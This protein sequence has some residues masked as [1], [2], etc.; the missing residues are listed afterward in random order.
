MREL[1]VDAHLSPSR[2]SLSVTPTSTP[3]PTPST[4]NQTVTYQPA[5]EESPQ[6]PRQKNA[7]GEVNN[8]KGVESLTTAMRSNIIS[9]PPNKGPSWSNGYQQVVLILCSF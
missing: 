9:D 3:S 4:S 1:S 5:R 8:N 2:S 6:F 7:G